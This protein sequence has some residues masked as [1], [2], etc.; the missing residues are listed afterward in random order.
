MSTNEINLILYTDLGDDID[1]T[2]ALWFTNKATAI[3]SMIVILSS[4]NST[5]RQQTRN[6]VAQYLTT[7][8]TMIV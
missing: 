5:R 8:Y 6:E 1:D 3:K 7:S 4:H 2:L